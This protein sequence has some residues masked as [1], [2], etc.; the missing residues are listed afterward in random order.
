M[1]HKKIFFSSLIMIVAAAAVIAIAQTSYAAT[2]TNTDTP[3]KVP[4]SSDT[5]SSNS[6]FGG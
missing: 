3:W 6:T 1:K 2:A 4:I 5:F